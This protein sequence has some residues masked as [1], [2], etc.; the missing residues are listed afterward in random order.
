MN[1]NF[2]ENVKEI[3]FSRKPMP[4][5]YKYR[6]SY[7]IAQIVL[8]IGICC[9]KGACSLIK[10]HMLSWALTSA[11]EMNSLA[12][13]LN[14]ETA[15]SQPNLRLDPSVNRA[16]IFGAA[17]KVFFQANNGKYGLTEQGER[18]FAEIMHDSDILTIEKIFLKSVANKLPEKKIDE[19]ISDWRIYS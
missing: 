19:L 12:R 14:S 6:I 17:E 10:V 3:R 7:K 13:F 4:V 9:R 2:L 16:L 15:S 1:N 5:P 18:F 8:I 11:K